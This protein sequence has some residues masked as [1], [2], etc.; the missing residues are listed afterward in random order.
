MPMLSS[1]QDEIELTSGDVTFEWTRE[2]LEGS[3]E[4]DSIYV[5]RDMTL[6]DLVI[7]EESTSPFATTLT[8]DTYYWLVKS[9]DE[10]GNEGVSSS[11]FS[12]TV[13]E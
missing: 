1:P 7:K 11:T 12:F 6:T 5:Y 2:L 3:V 10:A 13:N 4:F 9:F 8:N